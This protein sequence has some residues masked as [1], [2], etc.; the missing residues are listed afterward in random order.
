[1]GWI[2]E[3]QLLIV[4]FSFFFKKNKQNKTKGECLVSGMQKL[5][6]PWPVNLPMKGL[7]NRFYWH[8][9][10]FESLV[11]ALLVPNTFVHCYWDENIPVEKPWISK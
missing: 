9:G 10:L 11:Q 4:N 6:R 8:T 3:S 7:R 5:G 2:A 1:M